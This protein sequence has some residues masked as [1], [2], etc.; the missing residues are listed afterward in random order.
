MVFRYDEQILKA[1][2]T[3]RAGIIHATELANVP[4]PPPLLSAYRAEQAAAAARLE[5]TPISD[6]PSIAAWRRTFSHFGVKP[7]QH[8]VAAEALLRRIAKQGDIPSINLLVD[9]GNLISIRY[10]MPVAVFDQETIATPTTVRFA[11][12]D[13]TFTDLG[14]REAGPI[15]PEQGE[16]V[17]VDTQGVVSAR[18]WCWRQSAQSA[19]GASTTDA[20]FVIEGHHEAAATDVD[21]A[22]SDLESLLTELQPQSERTAYRLSPAAPAMA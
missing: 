20:L 21:S 6:V 19:T 15:H 16:V 9:I 2:P 22:L 4:S 18:R 5:E 13:E 3:I 8:R 7:T 14:S 12:G 1:F 17:F 11:L 10:A